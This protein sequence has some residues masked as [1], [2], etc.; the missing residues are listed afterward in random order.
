ML[1]SLLYQN[2]MTLPHDREYGGLDARRGSLTLRDVA[3]KT[4][5]LMVTCNRCERAMRYPLPTL[6]EH[7]GPDYTVPMLLHELSHECVRGASV[8]A[9]DLCG[10]HCPELSGLFLA[11]RQAG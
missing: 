6:I 1:Y 9:Y 5:A 4:D 11:Q 7:H 8:S 3:A 10:V 2:M